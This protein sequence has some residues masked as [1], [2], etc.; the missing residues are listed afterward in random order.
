MKFVEYFQ[1]ELEDQLFNKFI[2]EKDILTFA[3]SVSTLDVGTGYS[4]KNESYC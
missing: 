2:H 3:T 4:G 1:D